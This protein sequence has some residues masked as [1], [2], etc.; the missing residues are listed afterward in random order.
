MARDLSLSE[1]RERKRQ[2]VAESDVYRETL[3]LEVQNLR[4][5]SMRARQKW[6]SLRALNPL[7]MLGAALVG[8]PLGGAFVRRRKRNWLRL[9]MTSLMGWQLYRQFAPLIQMFVGRMTSRQ[10]HNGPPAEEEIPAAG[11]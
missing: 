5:Y 8:A 10:A 6:S 9:L 2:L 11:I 1:L 4:L 7:L 3:R